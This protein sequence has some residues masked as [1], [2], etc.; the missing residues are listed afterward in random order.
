MPLPFNSTAR[1]QHMGLRFHSQLSG[2]AQLR[3]HSSLRRHW[4]LW[5]DSGWPCAQLASWAPC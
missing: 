1:E 3:D 2:Q 4:A 5:S